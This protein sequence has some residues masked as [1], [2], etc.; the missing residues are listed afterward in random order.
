MGKVKYRKSCT[1]SL[2]NW[3]KLQISPSDIKINSKIHVVSLTNL[4]LESN[5]VKTFNRFCYAPR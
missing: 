2:C 4:S 1:I 5:S 3:P